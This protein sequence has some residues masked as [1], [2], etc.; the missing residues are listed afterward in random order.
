MTDS[1]AGL[2][3]GEL[4]ERTQVPAATLRS[5]EVRYGFPR[6]ERLPGGHRRYSEDDVV[7]IRGVLRERSAGVGL[8]TA[9]SRAAIA[10]SEP[11]PSVFAGL[12]GRYPAL[13]PLVLRKASM[14]AL[15]RAIEDE[16]CARAERP[17]LCA[18]FQRERFYRQ[19][20]DRWRELARTAL[21]V[22]VFA[23]F[24]AVADAASAPLEIPIPSDAALRREWTLVCDAPDYSACL[25]GWELP[26]RSGGADRDRQFEVLWTVD[27]LAVRDAATIC[28][29]LA[30]SLAPGLG[31]LLDD[32][33]SDPP[34][35]ASADLHQAIRLFNRITGY[36]DRA[37][38]GDT[39]APA[40]SAR[41]RGGS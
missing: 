12:R 29:Q 23:D 22:I 38:Y 32:V 31:T 26:S 35:R 19:A 2:S 39:G 11:E 27:P 37:A 17:L 9:I 24:G 36:L 30:R 18:S 13:E 28:V 7:L 8:R 40:T 25:T 33:P 16:C 21:R 1:P 3:I 4:A 20:E 41:G 5:W 14:L 15:S 6:P 34:P 10:A